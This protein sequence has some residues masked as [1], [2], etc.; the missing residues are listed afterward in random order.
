ML[1]VVDI[2]RFFAILRPP[3]LPEDRRHM[4]AD[5]P[6]PTVDAVAPGRVGG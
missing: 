1:A 6:A 2:G 4:D 3:P 5:A